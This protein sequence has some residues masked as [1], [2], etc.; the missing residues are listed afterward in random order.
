MSNDVE[1]TM[2]KNLETIQISKRNHINVN[3]INEEITVALTDNIKE[4]SKNIKKSQQFEIDDNTR[5]LVKRLKTLNKQRN[6]PL[7]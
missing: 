4:L 5:K 7:P 6:V 1:T 2:E 3:Q